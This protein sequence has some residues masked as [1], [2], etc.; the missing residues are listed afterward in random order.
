MAWKTIRF[1]RDRVLAPDYLNAR[2]EAWERGEFDD[3]QRM[4][5]IIT[6]FRHPH[7][8][9]TMLWFAFMAGSHWERTHRGRRY[10]DEE[11]STV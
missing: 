1:G 3:G 5:P 10:A 2:S 11:T 9:T 4:D 7:H 8:I 6:D